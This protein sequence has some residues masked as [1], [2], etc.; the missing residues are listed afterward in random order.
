MKNTTTLYGFELKKIFKNK[1]FLAIFIFSVLMTFVEGFAPSLT[2]AKDIRDAQKIL[3]GRVI[4]DELLSEMYPNI[5]ENGTVWDD[6]N[7]EFLSL[8]TFVKNLVGGSANFSDYSAKQ[9]YKIREERFAEMYKDDLTEG[10]MKWWQEKLN[11]GV[12]YTYY[13]NCGTL[14]LSQGFSGLLLCIMLIAALC[15][16]TVFTVEHRQRTDQIVLSCRNGRKETY[17]AKLFAGLSVVTGFCLFTAVTLTIIVSL[18]YGL[19]GLEAPVQLEVP[20]SAYTFTMGE[21]IIVQFVIMVTSAILFA[22]FA[23]AV[24]ELLKNSMAVMGIMIGIFVFG[25][26]EVI[27]DRYRVLNQM[28]SMLPS[29][30]VSVWA[31]MEHRLIKIG[32]HY[33]SGYVSSPVIYIVISLIL[34][35]AGY[36]S[37]NR[38]QVT[39]R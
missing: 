19:G 8:A 3:D 22:V 23:M 4:D 1:L 21:F 15:L 18:L 32:S 20:M 16:S 17:F 30:Q 9:L 25:Q 29:N 14:T 24:S 10:E 36:I 35:V 11:V 38:F 33:V 7:R 31:L 6:S 2:M 37:Y 12:P 5:I 26:L 27:P 34:I 13:D 39:G 28:K